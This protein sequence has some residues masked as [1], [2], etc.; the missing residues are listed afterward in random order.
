MIRWLIFLLLTAMAGAQEVPLDLPGALQQL[1]ASHPKLKAAQ[2]RLEQSGIAQ[3]WA[4]APP[5][6]QLGVASWQGRGDA[7]VNSNYTA[8][9]RPDYYVFVQQSLHPLGQSGTRRKLAEQEQESVRAEVEQLQIQLSQQLKDTFY[10][11]LAAQEQRRFARENLN[12]AE[13]LLEV[14]RQKLRAG[15]GPRLDEINASIQRNR[16]RQE[17]ALLESSL[18]QQQIT[19][20][21]FLSL[22]HE[23]R[24]VCLGELEPPQPQSELEQSPELHDHPRVRSAKSSLAATLT[25]KQLAQQQGNPTPAV[26]AIYDLVRPSY[27]VN[28]SLAIPLDWGQLGSEVAQK[29]KQIEEKTALLR[30]EEQQLGGERAQAWQAYLVAYD[31]AEAYQREILG[32]AEETTRITSYGYQ[33]GALPFFQLLTSQQQLASIRKD[34][35]Q[36]LL[37]AHLAKHALEATLGFK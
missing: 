24:L 19:L 3:Q 23:T 15:S 34:Y 31:Q 27:S 1:Q 25:Q 6:A 32:P 9:N 30:L 28:L 16:A 4:A 2:A 8:L 10:R 7:L 20:A 12:L 35:V 36:R 29:E 13:D 21:T 14:A 37:E 18:R 17:L 22:P 11:L 5:A 33:R 26:S